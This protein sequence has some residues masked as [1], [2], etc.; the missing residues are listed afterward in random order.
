MRAEIRR[1][2]CEF[3]W[4]MLKVGFSFQEIA[5]FFRVS[6]RTAMRYVA[7]HEAGR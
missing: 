3:A 2:K 6:E 4:A 5:S 7:D 1:H